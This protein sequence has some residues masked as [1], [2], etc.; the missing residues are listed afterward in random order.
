MNMAMEIVDLPIQDGD[1]PVRDVSLPEGNC[2]VRKSRKPLNPENKIVDVRRI[3]YRAGLFHGNIQWHCSFG[4][5]YFFSDKQMN[6]AFLMTPFTE[7]MIAC[8]GSSGFHDY[9]LFTKQCYTNISIY[10][11]IKIPVVPHKAVAEVLE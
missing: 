11:S 8:P 1:L 10:Q 2:G 7:Q 9:T 4:K 5:N 6:M 3:I